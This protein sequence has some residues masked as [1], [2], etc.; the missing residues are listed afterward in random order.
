M[1]LLAAATPRASKKR[2]LDEV[3]TSIGS[4]ESRCSPRYPAAGRSISNAAIPI[5]SRSVDDVPAHYDTSRR[6]EDR[7]RTRGDKGSSDR[8]RHNHRVRRI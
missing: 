1:Q 2:G 7:L 8:R 3:G 6:K 5:I 4:S